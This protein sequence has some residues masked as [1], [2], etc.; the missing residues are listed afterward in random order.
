MRLVS[1]MADF[2]G[3]E[4]V[5]AAPIHSFIHS[6]HDPSHTLSLFYE[7]VYLDRFRNLD[8]LENELDRY[9]RAEQVEMEEHQRR[10]NRNAERVRREQLKQFIGR[11]PQAEA[12][13]DDELQR[14][15]SKGGNKDE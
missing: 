8:Y 15:K 9:N 12:A 11:D 6:S 1:I 4:R 13:L 7:K 5:V 14:G 10:R 3:D 2:S